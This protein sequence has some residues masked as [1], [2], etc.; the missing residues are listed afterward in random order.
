MVTSVGRTSMM[1]SC[2]ARP[3]WAM[4]ATMM[5]G[6]MAVPIERTSESVASAELDSDS[7]VF[8]SIM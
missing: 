6:A 2:M 7:S 3:A 1:L 8:A 5:A 4:N